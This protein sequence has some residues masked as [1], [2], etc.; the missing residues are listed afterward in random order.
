MFLT[1]I[2]SAYRRRFFLECDWGLWLLRGSYCGRTLAKS[3]SSLGLEF[4][5]ETHF[6]VLY[7]SFHTR[8]I[9]LLS[10]PFLSL[11]VKG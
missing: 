11:K 4:S 9:Y 3:S 8:N 1:R 6:I 7:S 10:Q 5:Q 2:C